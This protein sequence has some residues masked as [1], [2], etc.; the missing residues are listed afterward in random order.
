LNSRALDTALKITEKCDSTL[1]GPGLGDHEETIR[2]V[3]QIVERSQRP[4]V[5]D[6]DAIAA[7]IIMQ[8]KRE[9]NITITPHRGEFQKLTGTVLNTDIEI[10][11]KA[12][13]SYANDSGITILLKG[14][15]DI[16]AG[17]NGNTSINTTGNAGL[18]VGGTGDTLAG[19]IA[20][21]L[22]QKIAAFE[23]CEIAAFILGTAGDTLYKQKGFGFTATDVALEIPYTTAKL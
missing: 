21:L 15:T 17:A 8:Q 22:A 1:L 16:V 19:L 20:S 5:L 9:L 18:T 23:A 3:A 14:P 7:L 4:A 12:V 13:S 2:T 6:A 10:G 11:A